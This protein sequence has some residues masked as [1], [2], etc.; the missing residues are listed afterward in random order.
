MCW[1][2]PDPAG[3]RAP[4]K[5]SECSE[6]PPPVTLLAPDGV[7]AV[8]RRFSP[9]TEVYFIDQSWRPLNEAVNATRARPGPG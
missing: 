3:R 4:V 8:Y 5:M 2:R 7:N 6:I 9:R 1:S